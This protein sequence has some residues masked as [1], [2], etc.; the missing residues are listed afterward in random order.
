[1]TLAFSS[2]DFF[3]NIHLLKNYLKRTPAESFKV[4]HEQET[5]GCDL[6]GQGQGLF[7]AGVGECTRWVPGEQCS[8]H[9]A[10]L[11]YVD[12][13]ISTYMGIVSKAIRISMECQPRVL[14][15]CRCSGCFS[16]SCVGCECP[17]TRPVHND[18]ISLLLPAGMFMFDSM[19]VSGSPK[20]W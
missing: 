18:H 11:F 9:T 3:P 4:F 5:S 6:W 1:M 19:V 13:T 20:R 12:Y 15:S 16:S 17:T 2:D 14:F 7:V 10:W 8:F